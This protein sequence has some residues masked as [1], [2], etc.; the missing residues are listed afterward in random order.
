MVCAAANF[1]MAWYFYAQ[2]QGQEPPAA[3]ALAAIGLFIV[4]FSFGLGPIPWLMLAEL[5]TTEVRGV[6]SSIAIATNWACSFLV[7]LT[8]GPLKEKLGSD[9]V[10]LL[11]A[12]VVVVA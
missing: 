3:I 7:T 9:G 5:F 1:A 11:Y 12:C 10:F 2:K 6:A 4:G 8:F